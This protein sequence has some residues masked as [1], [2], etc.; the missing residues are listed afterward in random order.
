MLSL[1]LTGTSTPIYNK[2]KYN[3][4]VKTNAKGDSE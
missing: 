1:Y 4:T 3:W 2:F